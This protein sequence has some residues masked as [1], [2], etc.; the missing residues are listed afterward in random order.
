[1][2]WSRLAIWHRLPAQQPSLIRKCQLVLLSVAIAACL[3]RIILNAWVLEDSYITFRVLDNAVHGYGLRWNIDE[4]VQVYTHPLWLLLHIPFYA[5]YKQI[6]MLTTAIS[7]VLGLLTIILLQSSISCAAWKKLVL[8]V[9]PLFFSTTFYKYTAC[10]LENPLSTALMAWF[11]YELFRPK[12]RFRYYHLCFAAALCA[13]TRLDNILILIPALMAATWT[14]RRRWQWFK[15][16]AAFSPLVGWLLFS[17]F[18]YGFFLP[19][20][21]YAKTGS[22][23][24]LE[25][26][27]TVGK[28]YMKSFMAFDPVTMAVFFVACVA[29]VTSIFRLCTKKV[30]SD[31]FTNELKIIALMAGIAFNVGYIILV[32]GDYML[33]RFC[34]N[35]VI[36]T[37]A[38]FYLWLNEKPELTRQIG[39]IILVAGVFHK[40]P[41]FPAAIQLYHPQA[42]YDGLWDYQQAHYG[43]HGLFSQRNHLKWKLARGLHAEEGKG[44]RPRKVIVDGRVAEAGFFAD[45]DTII[46]D[47]YALCD[48]FLARQPTFIDFPA[49]AGHLQRSIPQ[50]YIHARST[51]DVS[52][53]KPK[54]ANYYTKLRL[55]I[56]GDLLSMERLKTIAS[57][58]LGCCNGSK[59]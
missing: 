2:S 20:T 57:F 12:D 4:R 10:G 50:G 29:T 52:Q 14:F 55:I 18:Y 45:H 6:F 37:V 49:F 33:G 38:I 5:V 58:Q 31:C 51:G 35:I 23:I 56:S 25:R 44:S 26:Y 53:M 3:I 54:L 8:V 42:N 43:A 59:K 11:I 13:V 39:L 15:C 21:A 40:Y 17:L 9:M 1:M 27:I 47:V 19:N 22:G 48:A 16:A 41:L 24:P 7:L 34:S 32:G 30:L 28:Q 46:I 36:A